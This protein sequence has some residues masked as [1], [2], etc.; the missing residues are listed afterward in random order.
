MLIFDKDIALHRIAELKT[1]MMSFQRSSMA[2]GRWQLADYSLTMVAKYRN[3][4]K[5]LLV[6]VAVF[7]VE[8]FCKRY[9]VTNL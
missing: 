5:S 1:R 6:T 2:D 3:G 4:Y 8:I 7:C 9:P